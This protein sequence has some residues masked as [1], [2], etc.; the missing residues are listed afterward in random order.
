MD[1]TNRKILGSIVPDSRPS[2]ATELHIAIFHKYV[3]DA[4]RATFRI[5]WGDISQLKIFV[6]YKKIGWYKILLLLV[7][8]VPSH[9]C[10]EWIEVCLQNASFVQALPNTA[11]LTML[12]FTDWEYWLAHIHFSNGKMHWCTTEFKP[13]TLGLEDGT[14]LQN[15]LNR[16]FDLG[17]F[18]F[19]FIILSIKI[20]HV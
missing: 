5:A 7:S 6:P 17:T 3:W 19:A 8:L 2:R 4:L 20:S 14:Y 16:P 9:Q 18:Y 12:P 15:V 11:F 13:T 1:I 10:G